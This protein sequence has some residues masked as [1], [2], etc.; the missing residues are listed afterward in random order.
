M[1][2]F[3]PE[4]SC[5]R[6]EGPEDDEGVQAVKRRIEASVDSQR[7]YFLQSDNCQHFATEMRYGKSSTVFLSSNYYPEKCSAGMEQFIDAIGDG[8]KQGCDTAAR[9]ANA[10]IPR[11]LETRPFGNSS[12]GNIGNAVIILLLLIV[13]FLMIA[14]L[15]GIT[16]MT[17]TTSSYIRKFRPV[18]NPQQDRNAVPTTGFFVSS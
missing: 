16:F 14:I 13:I 9:F 1:S 11:V 17:A 18:R 8:L 12:L 3:P 6:Y 2:T 10:T 4:H 5:I 7:L 15:G